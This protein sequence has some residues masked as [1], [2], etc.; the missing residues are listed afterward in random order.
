MK[1]YF[2]ESKDTL[3]ANKNPDFIRQLKDCAAFHPK[4]KSVENAN[5]A[6]I[7]AIDEL[8]AYRTWRYVDTL[9]S[10]PFVR[11]YANRIVVLNHDTHARVFLPGLYVSLERSRPPLLPARAI[12]YKRDLWKIDAENLSKS[13]DTK[14]LWIFQGSSRTHPIRRR[15][16]RLLNNDPRGVFK[17][18]EKQF[19]ERDEK[20]Q[21]DY[22]HS[23]CQGAFSLC[24][25]GL[26]PSSYRVYESMQLGKCP[27]IISDD[28]TPPYDVDWLS[29]S[30][31]IPEREINNIGT[32]LAELEDR[33]FELGK[34]AR[35][36]WNR[37]LS[38][39][40]RAFIFLNSLLNIAQDPQFGKTYEELH[41]IWTD[42]NMRQLYSW[43]LKGRFQSRMARG[44]ETVARRR[45]AAKLR[46]YRESY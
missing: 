33:A 41:S 22:I 37:C 2:A 16:W 42:Q 25:R 20:D 5:L 40:N 4:I 29:C 18:V 28:W 7:I 32:Y 26:S 36:E 34:Q 23:I 43:S 10:C 1:I 11:R 38:G 39:R 44:I 35:V 12:P 30:L 46:A 21:I 6:D 45:F 15:L 27:V 31:R 13:Y 19:H 14:F 24:P 3:I 8:Y 9:S 17:I